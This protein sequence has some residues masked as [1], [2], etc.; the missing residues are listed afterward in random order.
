[1]V[2]GANGCG[3]LGDVSLVIV[4]STELPELVMAVQVKSLK[5]CCMQVLRKP[6]LRLLDEREDAE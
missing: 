3:G 4:V 6:F 1:M 2:S 5:M